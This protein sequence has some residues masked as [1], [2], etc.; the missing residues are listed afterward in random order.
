MVDDAENVDPALDDALRTMG[1]TYSEPHPPVVYHYTSARAAQAIIETG[2][3]L[4]T[5]MAYLNDPTEWRHGLKIVRQELSG[6]RRFGD[7]PERVAII[8]ALEKSLGDAERTFWLMVASFCSSSDDLALWRPY[9]NDGAGCCIGIDLSKVNLAARDMVARV[10]Y[11]DKEKNETAQRLVNGHLETEAKFCASTSHPGLI[12]EKVKASFEAEAAIFAMFSKHRAYAS[13]G[14]WR[15]I[16]MIE[17]G[18]ILKHDPRVLYRFNSMGWL[19]PYIEMD[20]QDSIRSIRIGPRHPDSAL[21]AWQE[22]LFGKK[23]GAIVV[24]RSEAPYG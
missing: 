2:K 18:T 12:R 3:I 10:V 24:Q 17:K 14:E 21:D 19:T 23:K 16:A 8:D 20:L 22:W 11:A 4:A 9:G 5:D 1:L 7:P 15:A 6:A 13:E